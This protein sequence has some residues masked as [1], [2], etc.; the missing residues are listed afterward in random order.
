MFSYNNFSYE[1]KQWWTCLFL[2][3][4]L[5][6]LQADILVNSIATDN[7]DLAKCGKVAEAFLKEGGPEIG[8]E[9]T[10]LHGLKCGEVKGT[11]TSPTSSLNCQVVL[12]VGIRPPWH[13]DSTFNVGITSLLN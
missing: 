9:F 2:C 10:S 13:G 8:Q 1:H 4:H 7:T 6:N 3:V 5:F 11:V 12:H